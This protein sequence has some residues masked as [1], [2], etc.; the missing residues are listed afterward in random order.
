MARTTFVVAAAGVLSVM[1][2]VRLNDEATN[3]TTQKKQ[4]KGEQ[5]TL[6][7]RPVVGLERLERHSKGKP[8]SKQSI[9]YV[10]DR[11]IDASDHEQLISFLENHFGLQGDHRLTVTRVSSDQNGQ[12]FIKL[13]QTYKSWPIE[14]AEV[15][16]YATADGSLHAFT[17]RL[18]PDLF[19]DL[20]KLRSLKEVEDE[21]LRKLR[22][23]DLVL[24]KPFFTSGKKSLIA[25]SQGNYRPTYSFIGRDHSQ[26][27]AGSIEIFVD[28]R[29]SLV[30]T[31]RPLTASFTYDVYDFEENCLSKN[32]HEKMNDSVWQN[33]LKRKLTAHPV[34]PDQHDAAA[35]AVASFSPAY[36]F[37]YHVF[38]QDS[39]DGEGKRLQATLGVKWEEPPPPPPGPW[40]MAGP[41]GDQQINLDHCRGDNASYDAFL[42]HIT[43]GAGGED[44]Y[45]PVKSQDLLVHEWIHGFVYKHSGLV[46]GGEPGTLQESYADIFSSAV[47]AW[48]AAGGGEAGSGEELFLTSVESYTFG[49]DGFLP[50]ELTR[51]LYLPTLDLASVDNYDDYIKGYI[52]NGFVHQN[53]GIFN[54]AFYLLVEGGKHPRNVTR[55]EVTGIGMEKAI[56]ILHHHVTNTL[57]EHTK[58]DSLRVKLSLSAE[59]L[60]G[61]CSQEWGSLHDALDAVLIPGDRGACQTVMTYEADAM[62][63]AQDIEVVS[64]TDEVAGQDL[65]AMIDLDDSSVATLTTN[66]EAH[67]IVFDFGEQKTFDHL[68]LRWVDNKSAAWQLRYF[69]GHAWKLF[70]ALD[71]RN[72][73]VGERR[74]PKLTT[75]KVKLLIM[76]LGAETTVS[77][78]EVAFKLK[79]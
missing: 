5:Q 50:S 32:F 7:A 33:E 64:V 6:L 77:L 48:V 68:E 15:V 23:K 53:S 66:E 21:L 19:A 65:Q 14:A 57:T 56:R 62:V 35:H 25:D 45:A 16:A 31:E 8:D 24:K 44:G 4:V 51:R 36:W 13:R 9:T 70:Y 3:Q 10:N 11:L 42:D 28:A 60:F 52:D 67:S 1:G 61:K 46:F 12:R 40:L 26:L 34:F 78:S 69:D 41:Q 17:G 76:S 38:G 79:G 37:F 43:V 63:N 22:K 47:A 18:K 27:V 20:N 30:V 29:T 59:A 58:F 74:I 55:T 39:Y 49:D 72:I 54:L 71:E 75:N 2:F 73:R